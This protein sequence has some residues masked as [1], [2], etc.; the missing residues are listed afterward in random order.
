VVP[1]EYLAPVPWGQELFLFEDFEEGVE[2]V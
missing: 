1:R 2:N